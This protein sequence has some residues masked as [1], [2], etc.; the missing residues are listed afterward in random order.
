MAFNVGDKIPI[1]LGKNQNGKEIK[2]TDYLGNKLVLYFYPKDNTAGCTAQACSLKDEYSE[3]QKQGYQILGVSADSEKSHQKFIAKH[4]LP[5]DLIVDEDKTL[6]EQ[7]GTWAEKKMCGRTYMGMLR[8]T[9]IINE[10][11]VIEKI[12]SPKEIKTKIHATQIL[13]LQK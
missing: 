7:F 4:E 5:F 3:L 13:S 12:F 10:E 8:T 6:S 11:G 2:S 9:F 1:I